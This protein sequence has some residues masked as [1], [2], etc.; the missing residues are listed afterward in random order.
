MGGVEIMSNKLV[1][2]DGAILFSR[3][4]PSIPRVWWARTRPGVFASVGS[5]EFLVALPQTTGA[6]PFLYSLLVS[7]EFRSDVIARV[8]GTSNSHQ[9]VKP[10]SV[11]EIEVTSPR[12]EVVA[13]FSS[14]TSPWFEKVASNVEQSR[15][16]AAL[17]D[18][19][20]PKLMSGELRVREAERAL[21][22]AL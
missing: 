22:E 4:N 15:T 5:T 12:A 2:P 20:L 16:L 19:L 1:V 17:R 21:A 14:L 10:G 11:L 13:A 3:L 18:T 6:T 8:T 9:R 7:D